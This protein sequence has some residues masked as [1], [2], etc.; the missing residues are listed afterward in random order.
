[1]PP[2]GDVRLDYDGSKLALHDYFLAKS[3]DGLKPGGVL[4]LV[5]THYTLDKQNGA[6]RERL[7]AKADFLG[8]IRLPSDAF[9]REGTSVVTDLVFLRRRGPGEAVGH[10]DAAWLEVLPLAVEGAEVPVNGYFH[11]HP[12]MVLGT[13]SRKDRLYG[14]EQGYS[15]VGRGPLADEL[16]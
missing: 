10:V 15:V 2:F 8:A 1:N 12:E 13:F 11:R 9:K 7:A 16:T 3:L 14:G 5:T 4:G 6:V